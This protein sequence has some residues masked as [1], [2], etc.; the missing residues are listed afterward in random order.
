MSCGPG[1]WRRLRWLIL[2]I[3]ISAGWT[4]HSAAA[5]PRR[6]PLP[7]TVRIW[8]TDDGLPQNSVYDI[9]QTSDGYLWVGTREGLARFDGVRFTVVDDP[10]APELRHAWVTALCTGKDGSLWV[11]L[12]AG[13][14]T[15]LKD[16]VFLHL[17]EADGLAGG[18]VQ[19]LFAARDGIVWVGS[20]GGLSRCSEGKTGKVTQVHGLSDN[21]VQGICD[22]S[23]G[24][25]QVAT[26]R[27]L[28]SVSKE[29]AVTGVVN[30]GTNWTANSLKE[31]YT[32][33]QG[34]LWIGS[35]DG[36]SRVSGSETAFYGL[37]EGLPDRVINVVFED[38]AGQVWVGTYGGLARL[39]NDKVVSRAGRES[40]YGDL[41]YTIFEDRE[42]NLWVGA[43]DGLYRLNPARFTT[44]TTS[45]GLTRNNVMSVCE[46]RF[47]TIWLGIWDG[48]LNALRGGKVTAYN[49]PV[50]LARDSV[51][52]LHEAGASA[53]AE[54]ILSAADPATR[55]TGTPARAN[56]ALWVGMDL[57]AGLNLFRN[58]E[59]QV[60]LRPGGW[61]SG[62]I[63]AVTEDT[64]GALWIGTS[65][66]LNVLRGGEC[67][68]YTTAN[69][70]PGN[71]VLA[72]LPD[73]QAGFWI[74]TD[75]GLSHWQHG[76]FTNY[77]TRDGLSHNA[78]GA[79]YLD[80]GGTLW[81]GTRGGGLNRYRAGRFTAYTTRQ[82]LFS[83]EI[84]E[85]LE[86]DYGFF[87]M[88]CRHGIFRLAR[89]EL[90]DLDRGVLKSVNCTAF[91]KADGLVSVQC[92]G[93]AKPA[94][95]KAHD[96]RLWFPTIRG[97]VAVETRI[98]TNSKPPPVVIEAVI[99]DRKPVPGPR[100]TGPSA[101]GLVKAAG[102]S[103]A[104]GRQ[105][106]GPV[107]G[108]AFG[109]EPLEIGPGRGDL[110][111]H[112]T[113]LSFQA[114][115]KN[116]F[117]YMLEGVDANWSE[118]VTQRTAR[119]HNLGPGKYRFLV[120]A[121]N[122]DGVWNETGAA[123][124]L[125]LLPH[126]W[127]T[128]W[129]RT[130]LP[131]L[132]A[133]MLTLVYRARVER[134]RELEQ[135]RMDIAANLHDDVGARL[136]KVAMITEL[137]DQETPATDRAKTQIQAISRTTREVIQA[138]DE[139]VWTI[140]PRNDSLENLANYI[141]QHAQEYFQNTGVRCRLDLPAQLPDRAISTEARHNLFMAVKEAL[142][143]VLKHSAA[144]EVRITLGLAEKQL[145]LTV[146]DNGRGFVPDQAH[147][148][149]EG[150]RN[151]KDRLEQI[152]GRLVLKS[153]PGQGTTVRMEV[154]TQ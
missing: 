117:M 58:G 74:G 131:L 69:G 3:A 96:G 145:T 41:I 73:G 130:A 24:T 28:N 8:Q 134:L 43:R 4:F 101:D 93:V 16:G 77:T 45:Q 25:L 144:S 1:I 103:Q 33:R 120:K 139:V 59:R 10:A 52:S 135:L 124:R 61:L 78:A 72:I 138:M 98:K 143:N 108:M 113:A 26:R 9:A 94:G 70:L 49:S 18:Q 125:V 36:L 66:G 136:T 97:V 37:A 82:G 30:F 20:R 23:H 7:Y 122:N 29:G 13:G 109:E 79:L 65:S 107:A 87:W 114:P 71:D 88:S 132:L 27:G 119:Y 50:P 128:W 95:W 54:E 106:Q 91:G 116:L 115:E 46:D 102:R 15:R 105:A 5:A 48:G 148:V 152:G 53:V 149:G 129:F 153:A 12:E 39:V 126:F 62:A 67:T 57:N 111:I 42:E 60:V 51:L 142:N 55:E 21:F 31:A 83:D 92:N 118:P 44:L 56:P 112:Y 85:I 151:M 40:V 121:C 89:K 34:R 140:N 90:D 35:A 63:R 123:V 84:Y 32:D 86:D 146:V 76:T 150:L 17:S 104:E 11:G 137:V 2:S 6:G 110:E 47:G 68:A 127:Q 75:A 154:E 147:A 100:I 133:V 141:F 38:H 64:Q 14:V 81:V 19:C 22:D 99:A 80:V